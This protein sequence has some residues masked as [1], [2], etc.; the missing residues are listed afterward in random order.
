MLIVETVYAQPR[1]DHP[2]DVRVLG[3]ISVQ[4]KLSSRISLKNAFTVAYDRTPP[5]GIQRYDTQLEVAV[6]ATF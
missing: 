6:V 5:D 2:G 3:E 4:S 1:L